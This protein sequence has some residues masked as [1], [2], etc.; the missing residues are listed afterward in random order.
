MIQTSYSAGYCVFLPMMQAFQ[1]LTVM[2]YCGF[3]WLDF[4]TTTTVRK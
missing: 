1:I 2:I 4:F 3:A